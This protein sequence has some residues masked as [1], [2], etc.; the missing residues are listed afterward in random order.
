L[1]HKEKKMNAKTISRICGILYVLTV[2]AFIISKL[3]LVEQLVDAG[4]ISSTFNQLA[5]HAL[6]YR[7]AVSIDFLAMVL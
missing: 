4:N 6:Q 5:E 3:L 2:L 7:L 1:I